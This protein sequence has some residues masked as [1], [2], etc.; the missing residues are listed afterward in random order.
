[1]QKTIFCVFFAFFALGQNGKLLAQE[2]EFLRA[3]VLDQQTGEPVIF[4]T[5]RLLSKAKGVITNM[6]GGFRLPLT[7]WEAGESVEVSSMG[8]EKKEFE[9][10]MLSPQDINIVYLTTGVL[11]LTEAVVSA[12]K[13][14]GPSARQ[15]VRKAIENI[16][17]NY[18]QRDFAAIGY[19]RDYQ[20]RENDYVNLNEAILEVVDKGFHTK[21]NAQTKVR[22][23]DYRPT[24]FFEQDE[25]GRLSYDYGN[26][27]KVIA[28]A[29]LNS[30]GGNEFTILR[31]HDALRNFEIN[32][33][34]FVN[35]FE[36]DFISNHQLKKEDAST[37]D[38]EQLFVISFRQTSQK[39][40]VRGTLYISKRDFSI[41]KM[42]Y[43]LYD[44]NRRLEK[45]QLN[46]HGGKF[47]ALFEVA[48][49]YKRKYNKMFP[50]YISFYNTFQVRKPPVFIVEE[51]SMNRKKGCFVVKFNDDADF[52][53]AKRKT[54]YA[55]RFRERKIAI[56]SLIVFDDV[57]E[58]YP[59]VNDRDYENMLVDMDA[60]Q[61]GR[62]FFA[63]SLVA[64]VTNVWNRSLTEEVNK[65]RYHTYRQ[66]REFFVQE[67]K[68]N[69][70]VLQDTLFMKKD[71][72]IF[73]NQPMSRPDNFD[74]YWMNTPL[75]NIEE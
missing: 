45:A 29:Y 32:S 47:E 34:D 38:E 12:K 2:Q 31:V 61:F 71:V 53:T 70:S 67:V 13:K 8:Y 74:D 46:K 3:K 33:Y 55:I 9:L 44:P 25:E 1:M 30:Y 21:D 27:K 72:P 20:L 42:E 11:S 4:A 36:R 40:D 69:G 60:P 66:Y 64:R 26:N 15:I 49:E 57:V 51:V 37:Q 16:P 41:H 17:N 68:H 62:D 10:Q 43:T 48:T 56:D 59:K 6:D 50:N 65:I 75:Q 5:V 58:L 39:P 24:K 73:E 54:N 7:Y 23:Y 28:N 19:Y 52:K 63:K 18:P 14:R 35:V 22:I